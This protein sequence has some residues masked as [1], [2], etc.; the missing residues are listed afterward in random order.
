MI[1]DTAL[2]HLPRL[3]AYGRANIGTPKP[4]ITFPLHMMTG[5]FVIGYTCEYLA[6][7]REFL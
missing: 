2:K 7:G 1:F 3:A 6:V 4:G 5:L